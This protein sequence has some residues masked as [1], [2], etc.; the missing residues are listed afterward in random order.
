MGSSLSC[1]DLQGLSPLLNGGANFA[2]AGMAGHDPWADLGGG[3]AKSP[4]V[5]AA[6][7]AAASQPQQWGEFDGAAAA[8][9]ATDVPAAAPVT[10]KI[11]G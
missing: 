10:P 2:F 11:E 4:P 9:M 8:A 1:R 3:G 5:S 6:G 7:A